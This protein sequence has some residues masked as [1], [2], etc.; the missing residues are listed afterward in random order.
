[1]TQN[2]IEQ[3]LE[4]YGSDQRQQRHAAERIRHLA[5]RQAQRRTA[6]AC[7]A[8]MAAIVGVV[9]HRWQGLSEPTGPIVAERQPVI[10][11]RT[12]TM[13]PSVTPTVPTRDAATTAP[14]SLEVQSDN[15]QPTVPSALP[16]VTETIAQAEIAVTPEVGETVTPTIPPLLPQTTYSHHQDYPTPPPQT[17]HGGRRLH[18]TASVG[19]ST[20]SETALMTDNLIG[21]NGIT[22]ATTDNLSIT[23]TS[24]YSA[25]VGVAYT[26]ASYSRSRLDVG[27]TLSGYSQ[28][29]D[30]H[31]HE[32]GYYY[33]D[34]MM[35]NGF[36]S[37]GE[38][39]MVM[40]S[41]NTDEYY[42]FNTLSLYAGM[43]LTF[44]LHPQGYDK[45]GWQLSLTPAHNLGTTRKIGYL[46]ASY[47]NPWKLTV[48]IGIV[49]PNSTIRHISLTANLL[50]LYTSQ[51]LHEFGIEIGI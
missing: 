1:M 2:D 35:G 24:T 43:P 41:N 30:L 3:L 12:T 18:F 34:A 46:A 16:E 31:I 33:V 22:N 32:E 45:A 29:G 50:P 5:H 4:Q 25:N 23:P 51:S 15:S 9:M 40:V 44:S 19:A 13:P 47:L 21:I 26:V 28:Q 14:R 11:P 37:S 42:T 20:L 38:A 39:G 48:G 10:V 36:G 49:L 8:V 6:L 17:T 7:V 27:V